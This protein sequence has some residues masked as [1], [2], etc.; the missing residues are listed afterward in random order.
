MIVQRF[1]PGDECDEEYYRHFAET[2]KKYPGSC[3]EVW[4]CT[5][6]GMPELWRHERF[7]E[8]LRVYADILREA[9][10]R[11]SLQVAQTIGHGFINAAANYNGAPKDANFAV[12]GEGKESYGCYCIRNKAF[13]EYFS[14]VCK[15]YCEKLKPDSIYFDDDLRLRQWSE[16]PR[17]MCPDCLK[18][19]NEKYGADFTAEEL[20]VA[21][22]E[23]FE[24]REKYLTYCY[25]GAEQLCEILG[26][27][28]LAGNPDVTLGLQSGGY[29]GEWNLYCYRGFQKAGAKRIGSRA[30]GG[31]YSDKKPFDIVYKVNEL[32]FQLQKLPDFVQT[33]S[34][35][36]ESYP[37]TFYNKSPYAFALESALQLSQGFDFLTYAAICGNNEDEFFEPLCRNLAENRAYFEKL[38]FANKNTHRVGITPF[39]SEKY[40][41][42]KEERWYIRGLTCDMY[43]CALY[44]LGIPVTYDR[45]GSEAFYLKESFVETMSDA[46]IEQLLHNPVVADGNAVKALNERGYG[47]KKLGANAVSIKSYDYAEIMEN[48]GRYYAADMN[49]ANTY[50]TGEK[51]IPLSRYM[52]QMQMGYINESCKG[53]EIAS[54]I[55]TTAFGAK[56]LL[57]GH[58]ADSRE[59]TLAKRGLILSAL[60]KICGGTAVAVTEPNRFCLYPRANGEGRITSVTILN[61]S[62]ESSEP[63]VLRIKKPAGPDILWMALGGETCRLSFEMQG[64]FI[65]IYLP[66][67]NAWSAGTVFIG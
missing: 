41:N 36:L 31:A 15:L 3:D 53:G 54:C 33:K 45:K 32:E 8:K 16:S 39:I 60:D 11:V 46:E 20:A 14:Q 28:C 47:E 6:M 57:I 27:A 65:K 38:I 9:G 18:G 25:S 23:D 19:F 24:V 17:C 49:G 64:E 61:A 50:F 10:I 13:I 51:I 58:A 43:D 42:I 62:I 21:I 52:P 35:E 29:S 37:H 5:L 4:F 48:G 30:G 66:A 26:K 2:V 63:A 56:W 7:L 40:Y 1:W 12:T 44:Y 34:P 59:P 67:L 55:S 22:R